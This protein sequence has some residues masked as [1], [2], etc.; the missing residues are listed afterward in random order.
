MAF[1]VVPVWVGWSGC[2]WV[3]FCD[4]RVIVNS[5]H[6]V[7]SHMVSLVTPLFSSCSSKNCK[8]SGVFSKNCWMYL[9]PVFH[10]WGDGHSAGRFDLLRA[11]FITIPSFFITSAAWSL[12]NACGGW[13]GNLGMA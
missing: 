2:I 4:C 13:A 11:I 12:W 7:G 5:S 3:P 6:A 1:F 8:K 9:F 10:S